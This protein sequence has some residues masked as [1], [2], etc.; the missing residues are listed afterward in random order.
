MSYLIEIT[1]QKGEIILDCFSGS[2]TTGAAAQKMG[3]QWIMMEIGDQCD[4]HIHPRLNQISQQ[5]DHK[6]IFSY[7]NEQICRG[8]FYFQDP[9][10]YL[11]VVRKG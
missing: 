10:K 2:G 7:D 3:R 4:T 11:E 9:E 6:K 1:T 8:F 5:L